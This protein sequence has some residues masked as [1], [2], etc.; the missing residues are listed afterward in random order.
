MRAPAPVV[1]AAVGG[2]AV[3]VFRHRS[4]LRRLWSGDERR[5]GQR[6]QS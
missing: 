2:A 1:A 5:I 6:V 3:I 4:N